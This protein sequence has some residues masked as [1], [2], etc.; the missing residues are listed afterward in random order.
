MATT[1]MAFER[2]GDRDSEALR[3]ASKAANAP[4]LRCAAC[5]HGITDPQAR[6]ERGGA[7]EHRCKN[8][9]GIVFGI[10]CFARAP[11][12]AT[13]GDGTEEHTWFRGYAWQ[14]AVCRGCARH[15]GWR[16]QTSGDD[17]F[18]LIL[19]RLEQSN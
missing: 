2:L 6:T 14:L 18:G 12:C 5:G 19:S 8:P 9:L 15:L 11:G 4:R 17:F 7:H 1:T 13:R 10:G 16:F 3:D